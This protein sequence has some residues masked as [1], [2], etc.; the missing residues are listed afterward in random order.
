MELVGTLG[1]ASGLV[2]CVGSGEFDALGDGE[3]LSIELL[4]GMGV[5]VG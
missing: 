1:L 5:G 4:D 2:V 3:E